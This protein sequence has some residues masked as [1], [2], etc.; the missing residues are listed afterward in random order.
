MY[1]GLGNQNAYYVLE[2]DN[3]Y[4]L[5][6]YTS[7][8]STAKD[9]YVLQIDKQ[10]EV[11]WEKAYGGA[12]DDEAIVIE[13]SP[14]GGYIVVGNTQ[15][16]GN[17]NF[18]VMIV[19]IDENGTKEWGRTL[20]GAFRDAVLIFNKVMVTQVGYIIS[21]TQYSNLANG[22]HHGLALLHIDFQGNTIWSRSYDT[23][24]EF[25]P[26]VNYIE[27]N[28]LY[29]SGA[30]EMDA[31]FSTFD[32]SS[33]ELL[34][35]RVFSTG[36]REALYHLFPT[37]DGNFLLSDHTWGASNGQNYYNWVCKM[38]KSGVLL[39]SKV[40]F[41]PGQNMRCIATPTPDGGAI[42]SSFSPPSGP[43]IN[44]TLMKIDENGELEWAA[45]YASDR[46]ETFYRSTTTTD[47]GYIAVGKALN[48]AGVE[49]LFV[50]KSDQNGSIDGCCA[51]P[52]AIE[53]E[54]FNP[55][56][57]GLSA[58]LSAAFIP[59]DWAASNPVVNNNTTGTD[60]CVIPAVSNPDFEV[61]PVICDSPLSGKVT[62]EGVNTNLYSFNG[63]Q[64]LPPTTYSSLDS[65]TYMVV[66]RT[67]NGCQYY[68]KVQVPFFSY[69][70]FSDPQV[71]VTECSD[72]SDVLLTATGGVA[73][74]AFKMDNGQWSSVNQF[75]NLSPGEYTF[76]IRDDNNCYDTLQWDLQAGALVAVQVT[77]INDID[78]NNEKGRITV[79]AQFGTAPYTYSIDGQTDQSSPVFEVNE[80]GEYAITVTDANGCTTVTPPVVVESNIT[81]TT[82]VQLLDICSSQ[83]VEL[84]DGNTVNTP[85][86]YAFRLIGANGCDSLYTLKLMVS[87][88]SIY[89]PNVFHPDDDGENDWFTV[90]A[91]PYCVKKVRY[92]RVFDRW[93]SLVFERKDFDPNVDKLGWS[94]EIGQ[95][96]ASTAVYVYDCELEMA[97][98]VIYRPSGNVTV[99]R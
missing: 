42:V 25:I 83:Q 75:A 5:A 76:F 3:G 24:F 78:C 9:A 95:K 96:N 73:P 79:Q 91:S 82:K 74:Y 94:G 70:I 66:M 33:G 61:I 93:G 88:E 98:G 36:E 90:Y 69:D 37:A 60:F 19:K 56:A 43:N 45:E 57:G 17:G 31:V 80:A 22:A 52:V 20:G 11:L 51:N 10:G 85:G 71:V 6:G 99:I 58:T 49:E 65:G 92:L 39:W 30:A 16:A 81:A 23:G 89:I 87:P 8:A 15:S 27:G 48:E 62:I 26:T 44:A 77:Q 84:P 38:T 7:S 97:S 72:Q 4:L 68:Y 41:K 54:D 28:I 34:S 32:L 14:N 47:G 50:V 86:T 1:K 40:Y 13:K 59:E 35:S 29:A 55:T 21:A 18:D 67:P 64:F 12:Q 63:G 2:N 46:Y 53:T